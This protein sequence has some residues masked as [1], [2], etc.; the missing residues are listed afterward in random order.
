MEALRDI[1]TRDKASEANLMGT[2][3]LL[4]FEYSITLDYEVELIWN[5]PNNSIIKW[6]FLFLRYFAMVSQITIH[7][8]SRE[9]DSHVPAPVPLCWAFY[10]WRLT[11][12]QSMLTAVELVLIFRVHALYQNRA[13]MIGLTCFLA[14]EVLALAIDCAAFSHEVHFNSACLL[15]IPLPPVIIY[16]AIALS[17]QASILYFTLRK[18]I[19]AGRS[20]WTRTPIITLMIRDGAGAFAVIFALQIA[21]MVFLTKGG[22]FAFMQYWL[23]SILSCVGCRLIINLQR[24]GMRENRDPFTIELT[25]QLSTSRSATSIVL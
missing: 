15:N 25:T 12:C 11:A 18:H 5:K 14:A 20:G 9:V 21:T 16:G 8:L 2:S 17:L 23:M 7:I 6:L 22:G 10:L 4:L 1:V 3:A 13:I 19:L 24:L